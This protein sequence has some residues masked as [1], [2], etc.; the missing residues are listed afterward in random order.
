MDSLRI[1]WSPHHVEVQKREHASGGLGVLVQEIDNRHVLGAPD[2]V[3]VAQGTSEPLVVD[4]LLE[5]PRQVERRPHSGEIVATARVSVI[6]V[7]LDPDFRKR[8]LGTK[9]GGVDLGI[10]AHFRFG[11]DLCAHPQRFS[12]AE[13]LRER[14]SRRVGKREDETR[15]LTAWPDKRN[16]LRGADEMR[17]LDVIGHPVDDDA[18]RS[19]L[20]HRE[21]VDASRAPGGKYDR[22]CLPLTL[23]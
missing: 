16:D 10:V 20:P 7:S 15:L 8:R 21:L 13:P 5:R 9:D 6:R 4:E 12:A 11:L 1:W 2:E 3:N 17:A 22:I 19:V 14:L 23:G 18:R